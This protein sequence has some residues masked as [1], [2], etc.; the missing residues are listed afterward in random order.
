MAYVTLK[1]EDLAKCPEDTLT[2]IHTE[3]DTWRANE[4]DPQQ[5]EIRNPV[6]R[7]TVEVDTYRGPT[8][9]QYNQA[10]ESYSTRF[11]LKEWAEALENVS[12]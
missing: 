7:I 9:Y 5:T 4:D 6:Y 2:D 1:L 11:T 8:F 12:G 10:T 3:L